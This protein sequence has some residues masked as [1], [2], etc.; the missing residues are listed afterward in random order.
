MVLTMPS[1]GYKNIHRSESGEAGYISRTG[2]T[3]Q[4]C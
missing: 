1:V 4:L 3:R 2:L